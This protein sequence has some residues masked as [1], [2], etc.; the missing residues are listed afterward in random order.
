MDAKELKL[1]QKK[2]VEMSKIKQFQ[3]CSIPAYDP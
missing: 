2:E 1:L 3:P